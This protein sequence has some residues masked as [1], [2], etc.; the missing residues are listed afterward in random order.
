MSGA[1]SLDAALRHSN[2]T[3]ALSLM[4]LLQVNSGTAILRRHWL[5]FQRGRDAEA[6]Q[7]DPEQF[8]VGKPAALHSDR[9]GL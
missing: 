8:I 1:L 5:T 6:R 4:S 2:Q 7:Q 3:L 9:A